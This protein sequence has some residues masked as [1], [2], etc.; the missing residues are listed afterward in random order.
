[1]ATR[2][3]ATAVLRQDFAFASGS[4]DMLDPDS[5]ANAI[6]GSQP[7]QANV[8]VPAFGAAS[9]PRTR[10]EFHASAELAYL[11]LRPPRRRFQPGFRLSGLPLLVEAFVGALAGETGGKDLPPEVGGRIEAQFLDARVG[12]P[13]ELII[14]TGQN[15]PHDSHQSLGG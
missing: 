3:V 15:G 1:M 2:V 9:F 10:R 14:E 12:Q 6:A 8:P 5:I 11:A 4:T 7:I 13:V